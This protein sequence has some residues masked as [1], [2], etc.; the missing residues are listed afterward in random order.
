[1]DD[2]IGS[3]EV[4]IGF[5]LRY[6]GKRQDGPSRLKETQLSLA[7]EHAIS[8]NLLEAKDGPEAWEA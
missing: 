8:M 1:M 4:W 6:D 5:I 2:S 3:K 7:E